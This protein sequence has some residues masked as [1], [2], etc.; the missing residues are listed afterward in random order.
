MLDVFLI[1][2]AAIQRKAANTIVGTLTAVGAAVGF[3]SLLGVEVLGFVGY[4]LTESA[5]S[6]IG[7]QKGRE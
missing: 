7:I 2:A 6:A 5:I 1:A 3:I 4:P